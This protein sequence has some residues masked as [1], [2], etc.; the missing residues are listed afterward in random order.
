[1]TVFAVFRDV[2]TMFFCDVFVFVVLERFFVG[3]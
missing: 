3:H 2:K 1:M